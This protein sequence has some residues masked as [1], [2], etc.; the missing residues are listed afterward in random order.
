LRVVGAALPDAAAL[1]SLAPTG[2]VFGIES[3]AAQLAAD[4]TVSN[5]RGRA[6]GFV[7][8]AV[9][10]GV[11]RLDKT[12]LAGNVRLRARISGF[13]P[14]DERLDLTGT[15]LELRDVAVSG[16]SAAT[17]GWRGDVVLSPASLRLAGSPAFDGVVRLDA[18]DA[19]PLLAVLFGKS[20]PRFVV[21]LI[22]MPGLRASV[23]LVAAAD[24]L[25]MLDLDARGGNVALRGSYAVRGAHRRGAIIAR[26]AFLSVGLRLDDDGA[27]VRLFGLQRWLGDQTREVRKLLEVGAE[28]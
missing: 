20:L 3:G 8:A 5:S 18:S 11:V 7:D 9:A 24:Q 26:K 21:R 22:A 27:R 19:R 12:R 13:D 17:S 14:D 1:S 16:A 25:A 10:R 15:R 4:V 2:G 6:T 23:R 28:R